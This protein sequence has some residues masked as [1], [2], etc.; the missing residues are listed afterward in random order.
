VLRVSVGFRPLSK[1]ITSPS[2]LAYAKWREL[3][4]ARPRSDA[5]TDPAVVDHPRHQTGRE[6]SGE[7]RNL[8]QL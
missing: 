5:A 8:P 4:S 1:G 2:A 7:N 6:K 3:R